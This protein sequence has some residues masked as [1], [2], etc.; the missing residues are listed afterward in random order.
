MNRLSKRILF[1]RDEAIFRALPENV[2]ANFRIADSEN[3]LLWNVIYPLAAPEIDLAK[4]LAIRP[5]WGSA[6]PTR[7]G[8]QTLR[9]FFWGYAISG[10]RLQGLDDALARL[11]GPGPKTEVDLFLLGDES[12]I[13]VEA[14]HGA[15]FG[16]CARFGRGACPEVHQHADGGGASC[17]YWSEREVRFSNLLD[18]GS[19][20]APGGGAPPCNRHYQLA[21]T[22]LIGERLAAGLERRF[23]AWLFVDRGAWRA[24][25][26]NWLD[27]T[28]RVL[29]EDLWR[30]M[31]VI[32]WEDLAE[33]KR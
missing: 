32:A 31:R 8:R 15:G 3:A 22:L 19:R 1:G 2:H 10:E 28:R 4:L 30:R 20:P 24:L 16:R 17:R 12:L 5:L 9:P 14:K 21:R 26:R 6:W 25:E 13:A 33:L 27:F 18:L 7:A 23:A 29:N 11:D